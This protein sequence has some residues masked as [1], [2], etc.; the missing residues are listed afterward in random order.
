MAELLSFLIVIAAGLFFAE[1]FRGVHVPYVVALILGGMLIGPHGLWLFTPDSTI[2]LIGEIGLVFLMFMAGL[3][4]RITAIAKIQKGV[5]MIAGLNSIIPF[6][7]GMGIAFYFGYDLISALFLGTIF[8]SSSIAVIIP[9]MERNKLIHKRLGKTII[10]STMV[11]DVLSL[12]VF[13]VILQSV[14]PTSNVPLPFFYAVVFAFLVFLR[15]FINE[16]RNFCMKSVEKGDIFEDELRFIFVVLLGS[17]VLF[18][19]LG[20]HS[21]IAGF[22][23]GMTLSESVRREELKEKLHAI[24]YGLFIPVFFVLIG[25]KTNIGAIV[26]NGGIATLVAVVVIGSVAAKFLSGFIGGKLAG[27]SKA[28]SSIIGSSTIPQLS[29]TLAVAFTG[30]SLGMLDQKMII[31][32]TVLSVATTFAGPSLIRMFV[33]KKTSRK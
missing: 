12:I 31:A 15:A 18:Q 5:G 30:L 9:S 13:S 23:A 8:I 33:R 26:E 14:N 32:M 4:T 24:S 6:A 21:I 25:S 27:F 3:E 19:L 16:L 11:E 17:V 10:A 7:A 29:T 20:L 22:F 28:E 2:E 1:L